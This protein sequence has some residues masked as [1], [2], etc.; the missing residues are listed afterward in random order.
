MSKYNYSNFN[1]ND[2][3]VTIT[4]T[5]QDYVKS[6]KSWKLTETEAGVISDKVY[7]NIIQSIEFFSRCGTSRTRWGY[8]VAGYLPI[9]TAATSPM[10]DAKCKYTFTFK[11]NK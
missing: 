11:Y 4:M 8:T 7:T 6:G 5:K 1:F 3:R 10:K 2:S 9:E